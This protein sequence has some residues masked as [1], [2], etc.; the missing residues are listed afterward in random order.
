MVDRVDY[1]GFMLALL[2]V[3]LV[4]VFKHSIHL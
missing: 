4:L 3:I 1:V 2:G